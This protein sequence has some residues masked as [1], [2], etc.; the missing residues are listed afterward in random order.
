MTPNLKAKFVMKNQRPATK[1][2]ISVRG[3]RNFHANPIN[4]STR[5]NGNCVEVTYT[6]GPAKGN[7][8][9]FLHLAETSDRI[10]R[11]RVFPAGTAIGT[12][13]STGRSS[14]P[15]LHYEIRTRRG[16]VLKPLNVHGVTRGELAHS[17][18]SGFFQTINDNQKRL[19]VRLSTN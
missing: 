10:V 12:V 8:A 2:L 13:G 9:R 16:V 4:W 14:A 17:A 18:R 3:R 11:G 7:V 15:H 5:N 19:R 6:D 1:I